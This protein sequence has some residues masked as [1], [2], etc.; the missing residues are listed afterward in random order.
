MS[1]FLG[2]R[3]WTWS[4]LAAIVGIVAVAMLSAALGGLAEFG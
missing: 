1:G 4:E 3:P 2:T